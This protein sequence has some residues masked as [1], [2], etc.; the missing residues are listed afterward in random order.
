VDVV[1]KCWLATKDHSKQTLPYSG[2]SFR[3]CLVSEWFFWN[4]DRRKILKLPTRQLRD[5]F[6][7]V[8]NA[9]ATFYEQIMLP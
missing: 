8:N 5:H 1:A 2:Q 3:G 9:L 6:S 4:D 7:V